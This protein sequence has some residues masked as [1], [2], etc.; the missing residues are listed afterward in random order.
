MSTTTTGMTG[1]KHSI[2]V[3]VLL[4]TI[5]SAREKLATDKIDKDGKTCKGLT[6]PPTDVIRAALTTIVAKRGKSTIRKT[7]P[8]FADAPLGSVLHRLIQF[9]R[10]SGSLWGVMGAN[11]DAGCIVRWAFEDGDGRIKPDSR[12]GKTGELDLVRDSYSEEPT[13]FKEQLDTV[14]LVLLNGQSNAADAWHKA[15]YGG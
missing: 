6:M 4:D 9:H 7:A 11:F 10:S 8:T 15:I 2:A 12:I 3:D 13:D 5:E 14:A 1:K